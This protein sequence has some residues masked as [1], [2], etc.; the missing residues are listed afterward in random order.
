MSF[1]EY[2]RAL[3]AD[4]VETSRESFRDDTSACSFLLQHF[5]GPYETSALRHAVAFDAYDINRMSDDDIL[6]HAAHR[7]RSGTWRIGYG[8]PPASL[9]LRSLPLR[10]IASVLGTPLSRATVP[11]AQ[12]P[13][14][15][16]PRRA[17]APALA[18][19]PPEPEWSEQTDQNAFA[20]VLEQ[21]AVSGTPFCEVCAKARAPSPLAA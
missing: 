10:P 3:A 16:A 5:R 6:M 14:S 20:G 21:A 19:T 13:A 7:L 9:A 4:E 18:A 17:P 12:Q 1:S 11:R 15:A 8:L 2:Q